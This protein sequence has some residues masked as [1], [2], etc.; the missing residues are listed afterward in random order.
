MATCFVPNDIIPN[1]L[2]YA[3]S[4]TL[5]RILKSCKFF[6]KMIDDKFIIKYLFDTNIINQFNPDISTN[7]L[8]KYY[9]LK[10]SIIDSIQY[11]LDDFYYLMKK[12]FI[13][14]WAV[15]GG[16]CMRFHDIK[17]MTYDLDIVMIGDIEKGEE[18]WATRID[19]ILQKNNWI[20]CKDPLES[21]D[22]DNY[23]NSWI[24]PIY[25][26]KIDI[27]APRNEELNFDDIIVSNNINYLNIDELFNMKNNS[28]Y[29]RIDDKFGS[30]KDSNDCQCIIDKYYSEDKYFIESHNL[31]ID[32]Q[33]YIDKLNNNFAKYEHPYSK[34][35]LI[36]Y[37]KNDKII[38]DITLFQS[39]P[40]SHLTWDC[41]YENHVDYDIQ[42]VPINNTCE[43]C[44]IILDKYNKN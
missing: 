2:I 24:H 5:R 18:W 28:V 12:K 30:I 14:N 41:W 37:G 20:H 40:N 7:N 43:P 38:Q 42:S 6:N 15:T 31:I 21:E 39:P 10:L 33:T 32:Q 1:I 26:I 19:D 36:Y 4:V 35:Y 3:D 27:L 22:L 23:A 13:Y 44:N 8:W 9:L 11:T 29:Q 17:K 16:M 25:K 34:S